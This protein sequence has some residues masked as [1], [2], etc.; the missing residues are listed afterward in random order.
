MER[1][2]LPDQSAQLRPPVQLDPQ[3][4]QV[5]LRTAL[6]AV[7]H[8]LRHGRAPALDKDDY[9]EVLRK[10]VATFVTIRAFG[11]LVGCIGALKAY[12]PLVVDVSGNAFAAAFR[13]PRSSGVSRSMLPDLELH[14]SLLSASVAIRFDSEQDLLN[15]LRV[16]ID[17]LIIDDGKHRATFLPAVWKSLPDP[18]E[19]LSQLKLKAGLDKNQ[20]PDSMTAQRYVV[21]E[22]G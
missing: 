14:I 16:G 22:I 1:L 9:D 11:R 19:F 17:G 12:R 18:R 13:D 20:W 15:Q 2:S 10:K 6:A 3:E 5:L 7:E 21:A 8:G 4:S